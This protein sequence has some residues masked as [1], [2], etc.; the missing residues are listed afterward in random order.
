MHK[1]DP[2]ATALYPL[3]SSSKAF[4]TTASSSTFFCWPGSATGVSGNGSPLSS[5]SICASASLTTLLGVTPVSWIA[6]PSGEVR[7][8]R[9][10]AAAVLCGAVGGGHPRGL[11]DVGAPRAARRHGA[12]DGRA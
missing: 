10:G 1:A 2:Y 8:A 7:A 11:A 12:C 9:G 3:A 5:T 6:L 4:L